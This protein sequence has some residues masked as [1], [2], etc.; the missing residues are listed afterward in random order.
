MQKHNEIRAQKV[1]SKRCVEIVTA[2]CKFLK[3]FKK[4]EYCAD[5]TAVLSSTDETSCEHDRRW[6]EI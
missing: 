5:P 6:P 1:V 2:L 3:D 4:T